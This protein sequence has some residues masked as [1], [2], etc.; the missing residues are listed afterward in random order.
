MIVLGFITCVTIIVISIVTCT[1]I[2]NIKKYNIDSDNDITELLCD[3][4][5]VYLA[6]IRL[7]SNLKYDTS[8]KEIANYCA[9]ILEQY[10]NECYLKE[11]TEDK[12]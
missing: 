11:E 6:L 1:T 8:S 4:K 9:K 5:Y 3:I 7:K 2:E 12:E 10:V